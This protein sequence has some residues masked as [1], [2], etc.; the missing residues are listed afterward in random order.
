[1]HKRCLTILIA[2]L[3]LL[4]CGEEAEVRVYESTRPASYNWPDTEPRQASHTETYRTP[5]GEREVTWVWDVPEGWVDAPEVSQFHVADYRFPGTTQALPGRLTVSVSR[6]D[7]GGVREN[8]QRWRGQLFLAPP[9]GPAPGDS[10][11]RPMGVPVG[12][13]TIVELSGQYQGEH[14][15]THLLGAIVQVPAQDGSTFQTWFFKML[16]DRQTINNNRKKMLRMI[17]SLRPEGAPAP[18][19]P[20]ELFDRALPGNNADTQPPPPPAP[21]PQPPA[22]PLAPTDPAPADPAP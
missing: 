9:K 15:P 10:V 19:L 4:G 5:D 11:S 6:G 18:D 1:M 3:L 7:G 8:I 17:L 13:A 20:E 2:P 12:E 16:G 14:V 22:N 21:T